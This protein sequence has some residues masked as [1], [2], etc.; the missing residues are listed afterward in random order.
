MD[1]ILDNY[2]YIPTSLTDSTGLPIMRCVP[3]METN[4][5]MVYGMGNTTK[6][7]YRPTC[8]APG[9]DTHYVHNYNV[10]LAGHFQMNAH[11]M[12]GKLNLSVLLSAVQFVRF[13]N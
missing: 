6:V 4:V 13:V 11:K 2:H 5:I 9:V 7:I 1:S 8:I 10:H 12:S 3:K